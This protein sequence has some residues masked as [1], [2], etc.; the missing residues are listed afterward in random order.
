MEKTYLYKTFLNKLAE[1]P[2][3]GLIFFSFTF[4]VGLCIALTGFIMYYTKAYFVGIVFI[5]FGGILLVY[6]GIKAKI[7]RTMNIIANYRWICK[8]CSH[9][10]KS[11]K[12]IGQPPKCPKCN[13]K[14]IS[15]GSQISGKELVRLV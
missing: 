11:K 7:Y 10:W 1:K 6:S 3:L 13:S 5:S 2:I 9:I 4:I 15:H 12:N 14:N 8:N